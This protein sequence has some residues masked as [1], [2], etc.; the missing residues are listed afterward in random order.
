MDIT[1]DSVIIFI[2][3]TVLFSII[4]YFFFEGDKCCPRCSKTLELTDRN[5]IPVLHCVEC[6]QYFRCGKRV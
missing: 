4:L 5:D 6:D 2:V 3:A 1:I